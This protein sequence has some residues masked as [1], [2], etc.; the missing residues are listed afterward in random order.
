MGIEEF[1]Q[2][3]NAALDKWMAGLVPPSEALREELIVLAKEAKDS[4]LVP[5]LVAASMANVMRRVDKELEPIL[6]KAFD[7]A[8][9]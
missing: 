2:R 1:D 4:E 6:E 9:D 8:Q 5:H 3:V 7:I